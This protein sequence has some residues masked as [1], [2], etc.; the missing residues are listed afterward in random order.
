MT[1]SAG[2]LS[3]ISLFSGGGGF[4]LGI[5]AVGF[6]T[7]FATDVDSACYDTLETNKRI[8]AS[9]NKPF[10]KQA[11]IVKSCVR[12]LDADAILSHINLKKG[13]VDLMVG[14]PPC[15][16]FS[17]IGRRNGR[18]DPNGKLLDDYLRLLAG[19][20]PRV[21]IFENVKGIES[22]ENG[23]LFR[24]LLDQMRHPA[25][26][27]NY[28]LSR[29][30][31]NASNYGVP[32]N[33]ER[34]IVIGSRDGN[35]IDKIPQLT[36]DSSSSG[37][38]TVRKRT[39]SDAFRG[40]PQAESSFPPN[41]RGRVHSKRIVERYA[42]LNPGERDPKTRINK[43]DFSKPSFTIVSG[44]SNSGGKGHIH[45]RESREVTPRESARLQTFPD[46]WTFEGK[47]AS[48]AR[49]QIGNAVP[50]LLAAIIANEVRYNIFQLPRIDFPSIVAFLDQTHLEFN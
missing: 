16:S 19:L 28:R 18:D 46:W 27:L 20:Q 17:I 29:F 40:L 3:A 21:F 15:Q 32:Q 33:R 5:E 30:C 22:V 8:A 14:G 12:D 26:G 47:R 42:N 13:D 10:L 24:T 25:A 41:H 11:T 9:L 6:T 39:V 4:D 49:R 2:N 1:T 31:L 44:S 23:E 37:V 45:P 35:T 34:I 48:D 50:P 38:S 7:L 36:R 43:L